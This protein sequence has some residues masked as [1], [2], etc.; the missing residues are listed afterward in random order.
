[1]SQT[2]R[3]ATA[4]IRL[5]PLVHGAATRVRKQQTAIGEQPIICPNAQ[6]NLRMLQ[7]EKANAAQEVT[8]G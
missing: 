5:V 7:H 4:S 3:L 1:M 8:M 2:L 6:A